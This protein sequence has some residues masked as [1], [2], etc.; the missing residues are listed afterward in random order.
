MKNLED[1]GNDLLLAGEVSEC[2]RLPLSTLYRLTKN[3]IL[4]GIK[5][6]KQWRYSR[7]DIEK[8]L[9]SFKNPRHYYNW[10]ADSDINERRAHPRLNC[11]IE[12]RFSLNLPPNKNFTSDS[13]IKNISGNGLLLYPLS[14]FLSK[15]DIGDPVELEFK[16][17]LENNNIRTDGRIV[18]KAVDGFGIKFRNMNKE[19]QDSII[20]FVG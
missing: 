15:I 17:N 14:D 11:H 19:C 20:H 9:A 5:V 4:K 16:L 10:K 13:L 3:G 6:G 18:R 1:K 8:Y 2:L 12:C 7:T